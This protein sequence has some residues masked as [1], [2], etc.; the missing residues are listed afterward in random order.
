MVNVEIYFP[1]LTL[2]NNSHLE[3]LIIVNPL[4]CESVLNIFAATEDV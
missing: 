2:H 3:G 1:T 4:E